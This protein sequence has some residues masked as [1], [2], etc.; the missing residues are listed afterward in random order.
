MMMM[1]KND[2]V[3]VELFAASAKRSAGIRRVTEQ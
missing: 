1:K 3:L 2:G